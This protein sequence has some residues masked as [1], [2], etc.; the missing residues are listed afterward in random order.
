MDSNSSSNRRWEE[1][2]K[3]ARKLE[4]EID[5]RLAS[6][7]KLGVSAYN[8]ST[9][10]IPSSG[11]AVEAE[12]RAAEIEQLLRQLAE[13]NESMADHVQKQNAS[14]FLSHTLARH[15]NILL[16]FTQEFRRTRSKVSSSLEHSL[17]LGSSESS[18]GGSTD[19][20]SHGFGLESSDGS[21]LQALL[22]ERGSIHNALSQADEV[23]AQAHA[24][25]SSLNLQRTIFSDIFSK[26]TTL[27][28]KFPLL[29]SLLTNIRRKKSKDTIILSAVIAGC[30]LFLLIY[31]FSK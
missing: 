23:I 19:H 6:Y 31:W 22:R 10:A 5:Q 2:R 24:T 9:L 21:N 18:R 8:S 16:E 14:E 3:E 17:L 27:G 12:H 4:S 1:L 11:D 25:S 26:V 30:S 20:S 15:S 29:N 28:T 13:V 7:S